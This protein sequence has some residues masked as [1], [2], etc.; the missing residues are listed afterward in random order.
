MWGP[1]MFL[2]VPPGTAAPW[3][4]CHGSDTW[5]GQVPAGV[6]RLLGL[7]ELAEVLPWAWA[8]G[9]HKEEQELNWMCV[10]MST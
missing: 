6:K 1:W 9:N 10:C 7:E 8:R 2:D 3:H 5:L 4:R